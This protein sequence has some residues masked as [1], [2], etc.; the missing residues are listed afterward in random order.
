MRLRTESNSNGRLAMKLQVK[1][2][3]GPSTR[4]ALGASRLPLPEFLTAFFQW[5]KGTRVRLRQKDGL[6]Q[7]SSV[8]TAAARTQSGQ[9]GLNVHERH[10]Q[11]R[12]QQVLR[13]MRRA[14]RPQ[15]WRIEREDQ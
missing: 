9:G 14:P 15:R 7:L 8:T 11:S 2:F 5:K 3:R 6:I 12:W 4:P 1:G 10:F 13:K